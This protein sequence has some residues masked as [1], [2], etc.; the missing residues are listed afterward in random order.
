MCG[1]LA[2]PWHLLMDLSGRVGL[3]QTCL[4]PKAHPSEL[5]G[6]GKVWTTLDKDQ[7]PV[8]EARASLKVDGTILLF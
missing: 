4:T 6:L 8:A 2:Q 7:A 3:T 5:E 1:G